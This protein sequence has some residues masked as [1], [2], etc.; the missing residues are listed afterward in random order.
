MN[1]GKDKPAMASGEVGSISRVLVANRGEIAVRLIR[2]CRELGIGTVAVCSE[3]D[4]HALHAELA[5]ISVTIGPAE[6]GESYLRMDRIL[7]VAAETDADAIHPGYG[8]LAENAAFARAC[9]A[10]GVVFIGPSAEVIEQ[11]G[12]KTAARAIMEKAGVPVVPGTLLPE[13]DDQGRYPADAVRAACDGVGYPLMVKAAF[14]GGGKG[15]RLVEDPDEVVRA[16]EGA[17][18][19]ARG[20][21]GN[22]TVY[23]EKFIETPRHVEFQIFGDSHGNHIH[24]FE[25]ECSIQRRH[26]K[27]IEE[28]PSPALTPALREKMGQ[29]AVAASRAV[30]YQGAG[31]VEFLLG[32]EGDFYF[33]EMNTRLQV[34]HPVT[35]LVTGTD[36]V[37]AQIRVAEGHPLPWTQSDL[38]SRGH[39]I[40]CRVYAEDP[41]SGFM[42]SLGEI[43]LMNEPGGPGVRIDSGIRQGD[44]VSMYYDPMIAKLSLHGQDRQ[45][46]IDRAVTALRDYAILGVTT[47]VEYLIDILQKPA[48]AAGQL[49]TGFLEEHLPDWENDHSGDGDLALAVAAINEHELRTRGS[50]PGQECGASG[51]VTTATPWLYL[52]RFRLAGLD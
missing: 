3:V 52:G 43:L 48:F 49:H 42:P 32:P 26:Q 4:R 31:T 11:M 51:A 8:F 46:A 7:E 24:M 30:D 13:P 27:I 17:A 14:G 39:A 22:G 25:R 36:L 10:A 38:T 34:E 45:A 1:Q 29:A 12:E 23:V 9:A 50:G 44:E 5:D 35:E 33:L 15:M 2:A 6:P 21:F 41:A 47:N 18:R 37:R 40:E 16:C 19:E 28:T 20:A